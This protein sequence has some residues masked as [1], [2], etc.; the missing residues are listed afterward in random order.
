MPYHHPVQDDRHLDHD[1]VDS[2]AV[3]VK[4]QNPIINKVF[5]KIHN[6]VKVKN[7]IALS[8]CIGR[9]IGERRN[10]FRP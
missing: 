7:L 1:P 2:D 10:E 5:H 4:V 8:T 9:I 6:K 3:D